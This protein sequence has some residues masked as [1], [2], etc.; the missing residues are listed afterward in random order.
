MEEHLFRVLWEMVVYEKPEWDSEELMMEAFTRIVWVAKEKGFK[1]ALRLGLMMRTCYM[2]ME[3]R[4]GKVETEEFPY[5][6]E[7]VAKQAA[8]GLKSG[9]A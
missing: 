2:L 5:V 7:A 9:R 4:F 1:Q 8:R 3:L 6:I